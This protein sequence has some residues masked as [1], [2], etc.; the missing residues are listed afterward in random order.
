MSKM[1]VLFS[2]LFS[3]SA[4]AIDTARC[5]TVIPLSIQITKVYKN[6]IYR[7]TPGWKQAQ[8]SLNSIDRIESRLRLHSKSATVCKYRDNDLGTAILTTSEFQDPEEQDTT[9]VDQLVL[10]FKDADLTFVSFIPVKAFSRNG[11]VLYQNPYSV[12]IKARLY[13][14]Q[15]NRWANIH[16]G[17]ISV[18]AK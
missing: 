3:L 1:L 2:T 5:P 16:M 11:F 8:T 14:S 10:S 7:N 17:M 18:I 6:S 9:K 13:F 15:N 4:W 12:K